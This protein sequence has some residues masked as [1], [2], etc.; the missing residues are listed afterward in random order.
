[1]NQKISEKLN[2][3]LQDLGLSWA[4]G[5]SE[6]Q[7]HEFLIKLNELLKNSFTPIEQTP[8]EIK[9]LLSDTALISKVGFWCYDIE[10][11]KLH[12]SEQTFRIH[13]LATDYP[14]SVE[15]AIAFYSDDDQKIIADA[16]KDAI[17]KEESYDLVLQ[18]RKPSGEM[19]WIRTL[20]HAVTREGK[21]TQIKGTIQDITEFKNMERERELLQA[22]ANQ[23]DK[24]TSLG[25]LAAGIAH[26]L[27][28]P[29]TA[30]M[31]YAS[32][33]S[34]KKSIAPDWQEHL[35]A[36]QSAGQRM[37]R[38]IDHLGSHLRPS[39][40]SEYL[41]VKLSDVIRTIE[42]VFSHFFR[43]VSMSLE[44]AVEG[45]EGM[46]FCHLSQAETIFQNLIANSK[47]AF[48]AKKIDSP[49]AI[50]IQIKTEEQWIQVFYEDNAGGIPEKTLS[51]IFNRFFTTKAQ[52]SGT[53]MGLHM[54]KQII[55]SLGGKI[56]ARSEYD[57]TFFNISLPRY[58]KQ[59]ESPRVEKSSRTLPLPMRP[60][61]L[62]IDDEPSI[63]RILELFLA[64]AFEVVSCPSAK[65]AFF[66]LKGQPVDLIIT[67]L[68]MP[69]FSG[70]E[71]LEQMSRDYPHIPVV[72]MS[73][74][75][76]MSNDQ[77]EHLAKKARVV[78][79][80]FDGPE[81]LTQVLFEVIEQNLAGKAS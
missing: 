40:Q 77:L 9:D 34:Q 23:K 54:V 7:W 19:I 47:D 53:G 70:E 61:V 25:T 46:V 51:Q 1:M 72:I 5:P 39:K 74:H 17:E 6:D 10:H 49:H 35:V 62:A 76:A 44:L 55:E 79:K 3:L 37:K 50:K 22:E 65:D 26:E 13:G 58:H 20:G 52:G 14:I 68:K 64:D 8:F 30:M 56:E 28:N 33:L 42:L 4:K 80:P 18:I 59:K 71:L 27:N 38:I 2:V 57:K 24:L 41:P 66:H 31:G 15:K 12:W 29:L 43:E 81:E 11:Q 78:F 69:G 73:G 63:L 48:L 32:A 16:V 60:R 36:M 75:I 21:V 45:E 67:D